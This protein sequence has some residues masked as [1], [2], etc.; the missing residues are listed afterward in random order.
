MSIPVGISSCAPGL[1]YL[2]SVDQLLINQKAM[3]LGH[4]YTVKNA[5]G[6]KVYFATE[7][8][9]VF[10]QSYGGK[11]RHI[12]IRICD[13]FDNEVIQVYRPDDCCAG[14]CEMPPVEVSAPPGN[15]IGRIRKTNTLMTPIF[16][17]ENHAGDTMLRI[18]G[19][20][21]LKFNVNFDILTPG[22]ENIGKISKQW[23]GLA[24][25]LFTDAEFFGISFPLDLDVSTKATLLGA[26]FLIDFFYFSEH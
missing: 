1:E 6:Q 15:V 9:S 23:S 3:T 21:I 17:I 12:D 14:C 13:N 5:L 10:T 26:T 22:G 19:P 25:E 4:K 8:T 16:H 2:A 7:Q 20:P 24:R 11:D 18:E